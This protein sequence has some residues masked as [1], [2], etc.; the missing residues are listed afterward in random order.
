[1]TSVRGNKMAEIYIG[2]NGNPGDVKKQKAGIT[3]EM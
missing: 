2:T 1:V 3:L